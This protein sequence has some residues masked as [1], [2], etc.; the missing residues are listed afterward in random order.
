MYPRT[1]GLKP[2]CSTV[3]KRRHKCL[4]FHGSGYSNVG[5]AITSHPVQ[6]GQ[7]STGGGAGSRLPSFFRTL[8]GKDAVQNNTKRLRGLSASYDS[9][10]T[11]AGSI[12]AA[13]I[14]AARLVSKRITS[15]LIGVAT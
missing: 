15:M 8:A 10:K 14:V 13:R 1:P 12:R 3:P 6:S 11:V 4:L 2:L 9:R 5:T 7:I